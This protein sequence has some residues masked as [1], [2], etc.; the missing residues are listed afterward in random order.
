MAENTIDNLSIQVTASADNA[1]RVFDRLA[2]SAGRLRS[3]ASGAADS[4]RDGADALDGF[5]TEEGHLE[6]ESTKVRPKI[7]GTGDDAKKAGDKAKKGAS[8]LANFWQSLKRIAYYR[9]IRSIIKNIGEAFNY[10]ITNLYQWSSAVDGKFAASMNTITTA[11]NYLKNSLAAMVSPLINALAPALDFIIDKV[12]DIL[13]WFNQ[14]FA[15]LSGAKTYTVAKKVASTWADAGKSAASSAKEAADDIKRTILGFDEINKLVDNNN[16]GTGSG[17]SSSKPGNAGSVLFEEKSLTGGFAGFSNAIENALS[18]TL[19]RIG[20]IVSGALLAVGAILTFS[21]TNVPLGLSMMA[22]GASGLVSIIGMNWN[23]L[24][25]D[26]KLVIGAIEAVV[27]GSLLAVGAILAFSGAKVGLGIAMMAAGAVSLAAAVGLNWNLL[28][29]K[30]SASAKGVVGAISAA[31]M[32]LG[33][34]LAFT[35]VNVPLGVGLLAAGATGAAVTLSWDWLNGKLRGKIATITAIVGGSLLAIG[36]IL[37]F[38][39]A[40]LPL[41]LGM[42]AAGAVGLATTVTANWDVITGKLRGPIGNLTAF[43]S[44][45]LLVL[46]FVAAAAGKI[47][48]GVGLIV[49]GSA[50]LAT[51]VATRWD[52]LNSY[53]EG[54]IGTLTTFLSSASLVLGFVAIA[55]G[56]IPLGVGL[57]VAG[58]AGLAGTFAARWDRINEKIKDPINQATAFISGASL[59]L[60]I[61][62]LVGGMIPL[63][64][65]LILAGAAG[66]ATVGGENWQSLVNFGKTA[67]EKVQEGWD[68]AKEF[69]IDI[70]VKIAGKVWDGITSL[71]DLITK[72]LQNNDS[73]NSLLYAGTGGNLGPGFDADLTVNATPGFGV[74][75]KNNAIVLNQVKGIASSVAIHPNCK[76]GM[77]LWDDKIKPNVIDT[78]TVNTVNGEAGTG[79]L[80]HYKTFAANVENTSTINTVNGKAGTGTTLSWDTF[81]AKVKDTM[82]KNTVNGVAG[83]GTTLSWDTFHAKVGNTTTTNTVNGEAGSGMLSMW[84]SFRANVS[85]SSTDVRANLVKT[86]WGNPVSALGLDNLKTTVTVTTKIAGALASVVGRAIGGIF[87]GGSWHDIPQYAGGTTNAHGTL[88]MAGEAGPEIVGHIGGRTEVLNKSQIASAMYSAVQAAMAPASANFAAAAYAMNA[89]T[90]AFDMEMFAEMVRQGVESAMER[91]RD[92]LRQQLDTLRQINAKDTTVEVTTSAINKA[93]TRMNRRAGVTIAPVGT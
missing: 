30:V 59:V 4:I 10:G 63:G 12:V 85:D 79:M 72:P 40:A 14:L 27:G 28:T 38:S 78:S 68:N 1:A 46:G 9:F 7:R 39:G 53:L 76:P 6:T 93:Q 32:A 41:G 37:A 18:N 19:S 48:L 42:L 44:G 31:S 2:S 65:G 24:S 20:L 43:L 88:F 35:G 58:A 87:S 34:I 23:G 67:I 8:G 16:K 26:V 57:I 83:T 60:G 84:G 5:T 77:I 49:A 45:A 71:Y 17:S 82:T 75:K 51:T 13:N 15:V 25:A 61:I 22:A 11:T 64:I 80:S 54:P 47:P 55:A 81:T 29:G 92:I 70:V 91:E 69:V 33:A 90:T 3:A 66:L 86:W 50:G 21:G 89:D 56:H 62:A 74:S 73:V 52:R 36:A